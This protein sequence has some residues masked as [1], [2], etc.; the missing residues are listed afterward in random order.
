MEFCWQNSIVL[1]HKPILLSNAEGNPPVILRF[2]ANDPFAVKTATKASRLQNDVLWLDF[3]NKANIFQ[4]IPPINSS[5]KAIGRGRF[6]QLCH[7]VSVVLAIG[8]LNTM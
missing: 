2:S 7:P 8:L 6:A 5:S 4:F 3:N 1:W